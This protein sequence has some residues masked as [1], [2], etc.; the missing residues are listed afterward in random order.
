[1]GKSII[2]DREQSRI[3]EKINEYR[4]KFNGVEERIYQLNKVRGKIIDFRDKI[5]EVV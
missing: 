1:M 4:D 5:N 2:E 3:E